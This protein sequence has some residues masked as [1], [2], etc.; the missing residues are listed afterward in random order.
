MK[1]ADTPLTPALRTE[2]ELKLKQ[3]PLSEVDAQT[4][5]KLLH[6]LQ[7]HQVELEMQNEAL[8]LAASARRGEVAERVAALAYKGAITADTSAQLEN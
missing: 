1:A 8:I 6:E 2:A 5:E 7:I 4:T 3:N